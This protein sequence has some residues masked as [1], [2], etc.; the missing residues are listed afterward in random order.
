VLGL[1]ML[2]CWHGDQPLTP[3]EIVQHR[4]RATER[5][6]REREYMSPD[7]NPKHLCNFTAVA[8]ASWLRE[9]AFFRA[10]LTRA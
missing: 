2:A 6:R 3:G 5:K 10:S 7:D 8:R 9:C 4:A 1:F